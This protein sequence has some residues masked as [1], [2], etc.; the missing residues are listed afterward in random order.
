MPV[1]EHQQFIKA[2]IEVC[3]DLARNVDIHTQTASKT[4]EKVVGGVK[5]GLLERGDTVTW[6]AFHFGIKQR[7]TA[8]VT[9]MEKPDKFIDIMVKG[10]FHSFVHTHEFIEEANGTIMIDKFQ[11]KSPF[12]L[13]GVVVDK[14]I[15]EKYMR[16]FIVSRAKE[17]KKIAE[18]LD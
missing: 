15:L 6:E 17:L 3:F 12:G 4:K 1:I 5:K 7:L 11:Y 9:E 18:N 13:M 16:A 10:A 14:L 2:S 8:R